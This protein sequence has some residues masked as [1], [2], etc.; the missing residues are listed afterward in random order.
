MT[1]RYSRTNFDPA[2][3]F[4]RRGTSYGEQFYH[5]VPANSTAFG[6]VKPP[7]YLKKRVS[8]SE[9]PS[10]RAKTGRDAALY[11]RYHSSTSKKYETFRKSRPRD[12]YMRK[13]CNDRPW[14][15]GGSPLYSRHYSS[16]SKISKGIEKSGA[17]RSKMKGIPCSSAKH[18]S[19]ATSYCKC[20]PRG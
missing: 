10:S 16:R 14:T 15:R 6:R 17:M 19:A 12:R 8:M 13:R 18:G 4:L 7:K 1:N 2:C 9:R 3:S 5:S 20:H 11:C